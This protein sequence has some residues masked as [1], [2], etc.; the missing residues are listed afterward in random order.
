MIQYLF[1]NCEPKIFNCLC[2]IKSRCA[3]CENM[4]ESPNVMSQMTIFHAILKKVFD[5]KTLSKPNWIWMIQ[6]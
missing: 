2:F 1:P 3:K 6:S 4:I 5:V